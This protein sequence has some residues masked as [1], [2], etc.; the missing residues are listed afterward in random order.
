MTRWI[1]TLPFWLIKD[2]IIRTVSVKLDRYSPLNDQRIAIEVRTIMSLPSNH[3][4]S[5]IL[6]CWEK[7]I[8]LTNRVM[9]H[10]VPQADEEIIFRCFYQ[11]NFPEADDGKLTKD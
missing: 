7:G 8:V 4:A 3:S 6:N 2:L 11:L 5:Q 10:F 1:Q 9:Y